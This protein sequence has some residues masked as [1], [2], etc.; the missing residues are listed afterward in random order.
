SGLSRRPA[1]PFVDIAH[2]IARRGKHRS[3]VGPVNL[4]KLSRVGQWSEVRNALSRGG[5]DNISPI[6]DIDEPPISA[7]EDPSFFHAICTYAGRFGTG[8]RMQLNICNFLWFFLRKMAHVEYM[9][10]RVRPVRNID[11]IFIGRQRDAM[12]W[13]IL[14]KTIICEAIHGYGVE[15]PS[16]SNIRNL[17]AKKSTCFN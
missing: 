6:T 8:H 13:R 9:G 15:Y 14:V 16:G 17:K 3:T 12:A 5:I 4:E 1:V 7:V 2:P 10:I 11:L